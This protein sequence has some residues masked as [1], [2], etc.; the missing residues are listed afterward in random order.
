MVLGG[1]IVTPDLEGIAL[2]AGGCVAHICA[3]GGGRVAE[4]SCARARLLAL[5]GSE[6]GEVEWGGE[7]GGA[8]KRESDGRVHVRVL[9]RVELRAHAPCR[10]YATWSVRAQ[11]VHV[12][13][14]TQHV[15]MADELALLRRCSS[16]RVR[17]RQGEFVVLEGRG[18]DRL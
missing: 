2:E 8:C 16:W 3:R 13:Y 5:C 9:P 1:V 6:V 11:C 17:A 10:I 7:V 4:R 14:P 12:T 15:T 18:G